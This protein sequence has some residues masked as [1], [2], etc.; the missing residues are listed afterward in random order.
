MFS[1][2]FFLLPY[3]CLFNFLFIFIFK[4][5]SI[6]ASFNLH[7]YFHSIGPTP[8]SVRH[9]CS[10]LERWVG[11]K[12]PPPPAGRC[13]SPH[14]PPSLS[15]PPLTAAAGAAAC[16]CAPH[17]APHVHAAPAPGVRPPRLHRSSLPLPARS[18]TGPATCSSL[19]GLGSAPQQ[20][21]GRRETGLAPRGAGRAA[22][23][24]RRQRC[25]ARGV[26]GR[27]GSRVSRCRAGCGWHCGHLQPR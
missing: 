4:L 13:T 12:P 18:G 11:R 27:G 1:F 20:P 17:A 8:V 5:T 2:F 24:C 26:S 6:S 25:R 9:S 19:A 16:G 10:S 7:S 3:F 14:G 15:T 21:P 22:A 23:D